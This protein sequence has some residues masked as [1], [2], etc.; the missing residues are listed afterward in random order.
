[1]SGLVPLVYLVAAVLIAVGAT[2]FVALIASRGARSADRV[3]LSQLEARTTELLRERDAERARAEEL[4]RQLTEE[5]TRAV[6]DRE[7]VKWV[8]EAERSLRETFEALASRALRSSTSA[9]SEQNK[10]HLAGVVAPLNAELEKL[11]R[12]IRALEEKRQ[13]AYQ[14][15]VEQVRMISEQ[16]RSLQQATTSLDQ[17]LRAPNIRGRWG[18]VQLRRLVELAGMTEHV[19]FDE[20]T[21]A[22]G[23]GGRTGG[24]GGEGVA[25]RPDM[26]V[27][28]P[29]R[30]IIPVDAKA[31]MK[32]YLESQ[33]APSPELAAQAAKRH[34]QAMRGHVQAL[35]QKQYW[36]RFPEA[37]EFVVMLVPYESG[38]AAAFTKDPGLLEYALD[39]R[40]IIAAPASFLALLRVVAYG[41][42]QIELSR[43]ADAIAGAGR[44]LLDRLVPFTDHLNKLGTG[45][46]QTVERFN[47]V[48]GSY[49]HRVLPGVRRLQEL[50]ASSTVPGA[51]DSIDATPRRLTPTDGGD[52]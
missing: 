17:A 40:V 7:R 43:N 11:D 14:G 21:T 3:R 35:A 27:H 47:A 31:P 48:A 5:K 42:M 10:E 9:L 46:T 6:A 20:Q 29:S 38:L 12:Q 49:E 39:N 37:P 8:E 24:A 28:L 1:M 19:D 23:K 36:S 22:G 33:E 50:G 25:G 41:W 4:G 44:E 2:L 18:E 15:V 26:V 52:T 45:L 16:Y 34:A 32:A 51:V 13:G 30:A